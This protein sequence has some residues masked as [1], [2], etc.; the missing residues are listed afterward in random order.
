MFTSGNWT[1]KKGH[2]QEFINTWKAFADASV[3]MSSPGSGNAYLLHDSTDPSHFVSFGEWKDLDSVQAWM[4]TPEFN[5]YMQ[6]F[7]GLCESHQIIKL[8]TV[9]RNEKLQ[10]AYR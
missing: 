4:A 8:E 9:A 7:D 2:E 6:K 10:E 3:E 1:V 5:S